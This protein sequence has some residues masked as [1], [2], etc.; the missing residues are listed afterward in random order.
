MVLL[1]LAGESIY[2]LPYLRKA[3]QTSMEEVF[4]LSATQIGS[5][6]ALF[7]V[8]ALLAYFPSG[9]LADR[10]STRN[11]LSFSLLST[12]LSG[13]VLLA[14]PS[15]FWLLGL[16]GFWGLSSILTFWA[17]LIKATRLWSNLK[18]EGRAY[19]LLD[20]GRGL[21]AAL[22]LSLATLLFA[23]SGSTVERLDRVLWLY[24][25]APLAI[26]LL[27]RFSLPRHAFRLEPAAAHH[28]PSPRPSWRA[29][30]S[31]RQIGMLAGLIF[32]AYW[33]YLGTFD[34]PAYAEK[35]LA[36]SK[37][38]GAKLAT[39]RDW[40]RPVG[41]LVAGILA[42]RF[43]PSRTMAVTFFLLVLSFLSLAAGLGQVP[44]L[45]WTSALSSA[46]AVFA[47]RGVYF[48]SFQE[49]AIP[50][51]LTGLAV[52]FVS[53]VGFLPDA[54]SHLLSGWLIDR[55]PPLLGYHYYFG[56]LSGVALL[57]AIMALRLR[58][59]SRPAASKAI[60]NQ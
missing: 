32:C 44:A 35:S 9:W 52:G 25:A 7:G 38:F 48:A 50:P 49:L 24:S 16:H 12:G 10:F 18:N 54:F 40:M 45:L 19:G 59:A 3:F 43:R 22:L 36:Q 46:L 4:A 21:V 17:A 5:L 34:F 47:L 8:L 58:S 33:L 6:N 14:H 2:L 53:M 56:L 57:G 1:M 27:I 15:Y 42:D 23:Q 55:Y 30:L 13:L 20:A 26:G 29:L 41:A 37:V 11:L 28:A 60:D 39:F 31:F 51:Q